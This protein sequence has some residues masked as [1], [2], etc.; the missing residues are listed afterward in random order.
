MMGGCEF[1]TKWC[2]F[3]AAGSQPAPMT[4]LLTHSFMQMGFLRSLNFPPLDQL[5]LL[6]SLHDENYRQYVTSALCI[7]VTELKRKGSG[8]LF[9]ILLAARLPR[10]PLNKSPTGNENCDD[11]MNISIYHYRHHVFHIQS[12]C[13]Y[14]DRSRNLVAARMKQVGWTSLGQ[15]MFS[16]Q[17]TRWRNRML[18]GQDLRQLS[19]K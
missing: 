10:W 15:V 19:R 3:W 12:D 2:G 16:A 13:C 14:R 9:P 8:P 4:L 5:T 18:E 17:D 1:L 6:S 11:D 7:H